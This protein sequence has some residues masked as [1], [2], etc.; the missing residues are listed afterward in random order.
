LC[1]TMA[2][3]EHKNAT[4]QQ[5]ELHEVYPSYALFDTRSLFAQ[6]ES[7]E[8]DSLTGEFY[9][10]ELPARLRDAG[11]TVELV[12]AVPAEDVLSINTMDQLAEVDS[13]LRTRLASNIVESTP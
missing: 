1:S 8:A 6:L 2:I 3:V 10:T 11:H 12:D 13:I 5:R 9:L 4:D 7:L